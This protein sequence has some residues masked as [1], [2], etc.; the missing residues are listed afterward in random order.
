MGL[1]VA[2][3]MLRT[4]DYDSWCPAAS[5]VIDEMPY[6]NFKKYPLWNIYVYNAIGTLHC[7]ELLCEVFPVKS[8]HKP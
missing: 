5:I 1:P 6:N 4:L 3:Y 2:I 7:I 8:N